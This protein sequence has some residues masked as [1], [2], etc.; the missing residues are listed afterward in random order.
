MSPFFLALTI[1]DV[2]LLTL[3]VALPVRV[4]WLA[5]IVAIVVVL[6]FN[7]LAW[8]SADS[9]RG[10]AVASSLPE[11]AQFI[12]CQ[13]IEPDAHTAG[14]IYVWLAPLDFHHGVL[15]YR[16]QGA[17]PR[18][19]RVAYDRSLHEACQSAAKARAMG[20][21]AGLAR[22][23]AG[24]QNSPGRYHAYVLPSAKLPSKGR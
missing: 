8:S 9:G 17:E 10:W 13:V 15:S 21:S 12:A 24:S 23:R 20:I 22:G 4:H 2:L 5:K 7:F 1:T 3:L 6:S 19:Y 18:A 11:H 16:P 14:A